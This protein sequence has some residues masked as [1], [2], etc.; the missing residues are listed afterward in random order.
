RAHIT[1][2][3]ARSGFGPPWLCVVAALEGRSDGAGG[4]V[5]CLVAVRPAC[6]GFPIPGHGQEMTKRQPVPVAWP[7]NHRN[8]Y[9]VTPPMAVHGMAYFDLIAI[10]RVDEIGAH[11][12]QDHICNVEGL[13]DRVIQWLAGYDSAVVPG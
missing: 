13:A 6:H 9:R 11:E 5:K 4:V 1:R 8:H 7:E 3:L 12:E 2:C 10:V